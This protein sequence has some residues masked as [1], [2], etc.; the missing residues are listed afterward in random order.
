VTLSP[1]DTSVTIGPTVSVRMTDDDEH[2]AVGAMRI[3]RLNRSTSRKSSPVSLCP[4]QI[5]HKLTWDLTQ[6]AAVGNQRLTA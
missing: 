3:G 2:G 6:A 1:L 4:P 5:P